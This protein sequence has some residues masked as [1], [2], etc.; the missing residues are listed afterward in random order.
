VA[1][2]IM[3][4]LISKDEKATSLNKRTKYAPFDDIAYVDRNV[5]S[6][7]EGFKH[8]FPVLLPLPYKDGVTRVWFDFRVNKHAIDR[9]FAF[10]CCQ[11]MKYLDLWDESSLPP[12][13]NVS[14]E[15]EEKSASANTDTD[16]ILDQSSAL[17]KLKVKE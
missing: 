13:D 17:S 7:I 3:A 9:V 4:H 11:S 2:A 1:A 14:S 10:R 16:A 6:L 8:K 12:D 15:V 5:A